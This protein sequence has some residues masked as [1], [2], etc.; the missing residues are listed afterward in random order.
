MRSLSAQPHIR[1]ALDKARTL[2]P[3][4]RGWRG[5]WK[6]GT[7]LF[8]G[9]NA[10]GG[11]GPRPSLSVANGRRGRRAE[12]AFQSGLDHGALRNHAE[13][14]ELPQRD[15]QFARHGPDHGLAPAPLAGADALMEPPRKRAVGLMTQPQPRP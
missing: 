11:S 12:T 13:R 5:H 6:D 3:H 8:D 9:V 10:L 15:H 2:I 4:S 7:P 1:S 14:P